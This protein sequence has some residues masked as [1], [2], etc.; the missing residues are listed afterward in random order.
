MKQFVLAISLLAGAAAVS[1]MV[2]MY[3]MTQS[4][5][6]LERRGRADLALASDRLVS[7]LARFQQLASSMASDPRMKPGAIGAEELALVLQRTADSS[8]ALDLVLLDGERGLVA[9]ASGQDPG[10][11]R[12]KPFVD[13]AFN[14]ALGRAVAVSTSFNR[15]AYFYAAPVFGADGPVI[16]ALILIA[17]LEAIERGFKGREPAVFMSDRTGLVYFSNRSEL[18]LLG[19]DDTVAEARAPFVEFSSENRFGADLWT[20]SAGRYLPQRAIHVE[21]ELPVIGMRAEAL[22]DLRPA[23][24]DAWLQ[25]A[26][27]GL[28][29]LLFGA[30][31]LFFANQ[32]RVL[33]RANLMLESRVQERTR[34]LSEANTS[35]RAQVAERQ[36]AEEALKCAQDDLV[37]AGKLS[38]LG[39][40]S[41]GISHELNQPLM[42][43]QSFADNA[44]AFLDRGDQAMAAQNLVRIRTLAQRMGRIIRNF[45]IFARQEKVE[46][47]R[48]DLVQAVEAAIELSASRL[49]SQGIDLRLDLPGTPVWVQAG[50]VR[51]QQVILNLVSNA[52][53]AME[54]SDQRVVWLSVATGMPVVLT[55][56]DTGPGIE[57][58]EKVF[59]PF[60]STKDVS[61]TEALGLGLSISYGLVQGFGGT[62]RAANDENGGAVFTVE[63]HPWV[64]E[65]A[66]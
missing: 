4:V 12:L 51:L 65:V 10:G 49:Q 38:A 17:N 46:V 8:G 14:G 24:E 1:A 50:E 61:D 44:V 56:R 27:V 6:E 18:A 48:V 32:R 16:R 28:V 37:Q 34:E 45:R 20:L 43:I 59:E 13:R 41:T 23:L 36:E 5:A 62:I 57:A 35:L 39:K 21:E 25:S 66:A 26:V 7:D 3:S 22:I 54:G 31:I 52:I 53:D 40:M 64:N 42:A 30:A 55:V 29:C 60:Y 58:P 15:R 2:W 63:M 9:G 11:W 19:R 47:I 33:A